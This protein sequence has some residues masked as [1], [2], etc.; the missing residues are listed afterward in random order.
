MR[1][2]V[3][4]VGLGYVGLPLAMLVGQSGHRVLGFDVDLSVTEKLR[5][6]H[7]HI[8]DVENSLIQQFMLTGGRFS[9]REEDLADSTIF[10]IC[11]PTPLAKNNQPDLT[12]VERA[13]KTVA[14][15]VKP[16]SLVILESTTYPGTTRD[17][18]APIL[19]EGSKLQSGQDFHLVFS[20]ERVDPGNTNFSLANTPKVVGGLTPKCSQQASDFY[21]SLGLTVVSAKGL[22]E[23][24]MAK[25]LE[26]TYRH[27]NI[28]LVNEMVRFCRPLGIDLSDSIR[29]AATKPFG[30][31]PFYPGPGVG[32]HCI[33]IDPHYLSYQVQARLGYA[34]KFVELAQ[35]IN[36]G[37][38]AYVVQRTQEIL[39]GMG[40]SVSGSNILVLGIT[41][42]PNVADL[43]ETPSR[44]VVRGL[45][46]AGAIVSFHDPHVE[47]WDLDG[48]PV[49]RID[50]ADCAHYDV[51]L[52]LQAHA[53]YIQEP[54]I[55]VKS[56]SKVLDTSSRLYGA[57][58][59]YL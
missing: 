15:H 11:V 58:V 18:V 44:D 3:C 17:V 47:R 34:F 26:N 52:V 6:G 29:C 5:L 28:A 10:I 59:D 46:D 36:A 55:V 42:K 20:P 13:S 35:E 37:M 12:Y 50:M 54:S 40:K 53:E 24:E 56:A 39:N 33:P 8:G 48:D 4:I 32:G 31:E 21:S 19:G 7:S 43:R 16:G 49:P 23:A 45:R 57:N 2:D 30:F 14:K 38:P 25:L 22:E 27:V 9:S 1:R 41:Y 51:S